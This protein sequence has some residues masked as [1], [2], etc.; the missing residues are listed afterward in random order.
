MIQV[1]LQAVPAQTLTVILG[2]QSCQLNV[3]SKL[4]VIYMDVFINNAVVILGVQC[5][6]ANRIIRSVYLGFT[7][8]LIFV[9]TQGS[10]DPSYQGLG[11]RF[12]LEYLEEADLAVLG[13]AA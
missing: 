13:F 2:G 12:L 5:Q 1:P 10:S 8:D 11:S 4:G 7:G 9:D 3:F 6:N